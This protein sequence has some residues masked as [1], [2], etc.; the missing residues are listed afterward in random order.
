MSTQSNAENQ[1]KLGGNPQ[2]GPYPPTIEKIVDACVLHAGDLIRAAQLTHSDGLPNIAYHLAVLALEELGKAELVCVS[3]LANISNAE[4]SDRYI[5]DHVRKLFWAL[6]GPSFGREVI[7]APQLEAYKGIAQEIHETRLMALYVST[8]HPDQPPPKDSVGNKEAENLISLATSRLELAKLA[9]PAKLSTEQQET[10]SWFLR[11][12]E[13][14]E[15]RKYVFSQVSME[16]LVELGNPLDW[17][18]WLHSQFELSEAQARA[19]A[20]QELRRTEPH[21]AEANK[22]KWKIRFRLCSD[23]HSIRPKLLSQWN[24][25]V[26]LLQLFPGDNNKRKILVELTLPMSVPV[27]ALWWAGWA[28]AQRFVVA[29]NIGTMGFFWWYLPTQTSRYYERILDLESNSDLLLERNPILKVNWGNRAMSEQDLNRIALCF[30]M[31]P[32]PDQAKMHTPFNHYATAL[33][34]LSKN[35]I[36]TQFEPTIYG[37]FYQALKTG[38]KQYGDWDAS[39]SFAEALKDKTR[40]FLPPDVEHQ[41]IEGKT[42]DQYVEIGEQLES[43]QSQNQ[44]ISLTDAAAVKILADL[45]F[46]WRFG[47]LAKARAPSPTRA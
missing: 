16:K 40:P 2:W 44:A 35:D 5:E 1:T 10:M 37:H 47:E 7:S 14:Q 9:K 45:Y 28:Y 46:T 32:G 25:Q 3:H 12:T 33:S 31:F 26:P 22:P 13:D 6:W 19:L 24:S 18:E 39:G 11:A 15:K 17:A 29:L 30:A 41:G 43:R 21:E 4:R 36:H 23:S 38:M 8:S 34:F 27:Q 42:L 20:E